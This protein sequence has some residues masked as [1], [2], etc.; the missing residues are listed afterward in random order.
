[1]QKCKCGKEWSYSDETPALDFIFSELKSFAFSKK[2]HLGLGDIR[3][4]QGHLEELEERA[5]QIVSTTKAHK[6]I[7]SKK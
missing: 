4:T 2:T 5:R 6:L 1:M 7:N 3:I